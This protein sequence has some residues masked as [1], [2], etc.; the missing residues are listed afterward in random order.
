MEIADN[1]DMSDEMTAGERGC[2]TFSSSVFS[3]ERSA[4]NIIGKGR[5]RCS[6]RRDRFEMSGTGGMVEPFSLAMTLWDQDRR[7]T[8]WRH[9]TREC[10]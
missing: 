7:L 2:A 3:G 8:D 1:E 4:E 9:A 6:V 5:L 10:T